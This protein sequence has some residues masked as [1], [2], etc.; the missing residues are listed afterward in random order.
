MYQ[1]RNLFYKV[2]TLEDVTSYMHMLY[3]TLATILKNSEKKS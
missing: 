2:Y 1:F 3:I